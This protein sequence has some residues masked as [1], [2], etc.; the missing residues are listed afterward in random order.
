MAAG[1]V[2]A[3]HIKASHKNA[4][5]L[6]KTTEPLPA[7]LAR[8]KGLT[9]HERAQIVEQAIMLLEGFYVHLPL[10]RAMYAVDPVRRLRLL[11]HRL[12]HYGSDL[13]FHSEMIDI[14]ASV[15][16]LHT[17]YVLPAPFATAHAWLPFKVEA[18]FTRGVRQYIVTHKVKW[19]SRRGHRDFREGAEV[20]YWNGVPIE[21]A[22]D[23]A[24]IQSGG[25]NPA[26]RRA[27]GLAALTYRFLGLSSPPD[28]EWVTVTYR[29]TARSKLKD[30]RVHWLV[31]TM[32][33][34]KLGPR[35]LAV[36][37]ENLRRLNRLLF[38]P[39]VDE[40]DPF[41]VSTVER[42]EGTFG[43]IRIFTFDV[44]DADDLVRRFIGYTKML[45]DTKGLI[46]DVRDNG[47]GRTRAGERLIQLIAPG[48]PKVAPEVV[49]F[50]NTPLTLRLCK[51]R[52]SDL[53]LGPGGLSSWIPSIERS[54]QTG[55]T[56]SA[57]FPYT[58]PKACNDTGPI[59]GGPVIVIA[60]ALCYSATE[61]F[62][63]GFQD[64][65]G[66]ILGVHESTGGGGANVRTYSELR[67]YFGRARPFAKPLPKDTELRVAIRRSIRVGPQAG[68]DVEDF[69]VTPDFR[70]DLTRRDLLHQN[71]DLIDYAAK[72]LA[73]RARTGSWRAAPTP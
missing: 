18:C 56:F 32:P 37:V 63:A 68:N 15:R 2:P 10:K 50:V 59:Y 72:L 34:G 31:A 65:G 42:P 8:A 62:V 9:H 35:G 73:D 13:Q 41:R 5:G 64:H 45:K 30:I 12:R 3:H 21:R 43:Y 54:I 24:A 48:R 28:E 61:Y 51:L 36:Q 44:P 67:E 60:N 49:Y 11:Q 47:G 27:L 46:V 19:F 14:F 26:A 58:D 33:A 16:D 23:V 1:Y 40:L 7:F 4:R 52:K 70:Y 53:T 22:I 29:A 55:A 17:N 6:L 20:L 66:K 69:G 71:A 25:A 38:Q 57:S 39:Q